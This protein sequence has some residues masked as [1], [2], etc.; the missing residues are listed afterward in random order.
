MLFCIERKT[1]RQ[2]RQRKM[3]KMSLVPVFVVPVHRL[4]FLR[5]FESTTSRVFEEYALVMK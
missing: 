2:V 1:V 4:L 5:N 3:I